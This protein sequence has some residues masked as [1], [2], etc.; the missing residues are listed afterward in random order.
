M[1]SYFPR[2]VDLTMKGDV[3]HKTKLLGVAA[4]GAV[5]GF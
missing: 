2:V 1:F 3:L 4:A 5:H